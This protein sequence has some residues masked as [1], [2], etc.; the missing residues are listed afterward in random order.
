MVYYAENQFHVKS[1]REQSISLLC[2]WAEQIN[3]ANN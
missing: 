2:G 3:D 1:E